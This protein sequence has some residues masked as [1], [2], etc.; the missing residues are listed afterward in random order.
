MR[1][2][3]QRGTIGGGGGRCAGIR[4]SAGEGV[5]G[6]ERVQID[7]SETAVREVAEWAS[8]AFGRDVLVGWSGLDGVAEWA[9]VG[10]GD[11]G[12]MCVAGGGRATE[13]LVISLGTAEGT[14][15]GAGGDGRDIPPSACGTAAAG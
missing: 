7:V 9:G 14:E 6:Q 2:I 15:E 1:R 10:E 11:G 3:D 4:W 12:Y 13:Q 5:C 8:E